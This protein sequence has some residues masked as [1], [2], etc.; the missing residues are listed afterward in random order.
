M[1]A[2]SVINHPRL[3][4]G[5]GSSVRLIKENKANGNIPYNHIYLYECS[6]SC[7]FPKKAKS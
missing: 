3:S 4:F 6:L 2:T 5:Q 7:T 1:N